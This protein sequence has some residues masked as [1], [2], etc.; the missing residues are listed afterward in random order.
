MGGGGGGLCQNAGF[1][2]PFEVKVLPECHKQKVVKREQQS[3]KCGRQRERERERE[4]A[5]STSQTVSH[6]NSEVDNTSMGLWDKHW[7]WN[8]V[9]V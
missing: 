7:E 5:L 1:F 3:R 4:R 8:K 6:A 9:K 2:F